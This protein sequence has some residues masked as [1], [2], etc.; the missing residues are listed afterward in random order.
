MRLLVQTKL[1][2]NFTVKKVGKS[3]QPYHPECTRSRLISDE[4]QKERISQEAIKEVEERGSVLMRFRMALMKVK[5]E[6]I[7]AN[8]NL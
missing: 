5:R 3:L 6:E 8:N 7:Q 4:S 2:G 1:L